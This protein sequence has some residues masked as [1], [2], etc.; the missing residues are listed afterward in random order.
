MSMRFAGSKGWPYHAPTMSSMRGAGASLRLCHSHASFS[1]TSATG[2]SA[3]AGSSCC[4]GS[5]AASP[6]AG[7]CSALPELQGKK[8]HH[9]PSGSAA[10]AG[11]AASR[12]PVGCS[13]TV[14]PVCSSTSWPEGS[15]TVTLFTTSCTLTATPAGA[16]SCSATRTAQPRRSEEAGEQGLGASPAALASTYSLNPPAKNSARR[17]QQPRPAHSSSY[18]MQR[19]P[20]L[21]ASCGP[22]IEAS[23]SASPAWLSSIV[24]K[25]V[26]PTRAGSSMP[27]EPRHCR[28]AL[29]RRS[30]KTVHGSSARKTKSTPAT[31]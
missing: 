25:R 23:T 8:I 29:A 1:S 20:P 10:A 19:P 17:S 22:V 2:A 26:R 5:A 14:R 30:T 24:A 9:V 12:G 7:A 11:P 28:T 27:S 13:R 15:S 18:L 31:R 6:S 4:S 21:S 3:S 16:P